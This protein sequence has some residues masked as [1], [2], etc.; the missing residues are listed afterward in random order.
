MLWGIKAKEKLCL[1]LQ[2]TGKGI[3]GLRGYTLF[4]NVF[5]LCLDLFY[6]PDLEL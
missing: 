4:V 3:M 1:R 5:I 6:N 2:I